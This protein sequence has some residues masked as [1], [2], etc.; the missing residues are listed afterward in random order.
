MTT[1]EIRHDFITIHKFCLF[2]Y[3]FYNKCLDILID[4]INAFKGKQIFFFQQLRG[5]NVKFRQIPQI[6]NLCHQ[7]I[8]EVLFRSLP[9]KNS[10]QQHRLLQVL[11]N[12]LELNHLHIHMLL[13]CAHKPLHSLTLIFSKHQ[14]QMQMIFINLRRF[15]NLLFNQDY[16]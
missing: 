16:L 4:I 1:K 5:Y 3:I 2:F 7:L 10:V 9:I 14:H 8:K 6:H 12:F 15:Q 13:E 11:V